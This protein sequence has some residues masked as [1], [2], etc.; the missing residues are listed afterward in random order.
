M[1]AMAFRVRPPWDGHW[2][3]SPPDGSAASAGAWVVVAVQSTLEQDSF[4]PAQPPGEGERRAS[5]RYPCT[6]RGPDHVVIRSGTQSCWARP[7]DV[8]V[9]GIGLLLA[10]PVTPG[11]ELTI[12]MRR[13]R[14]NLTALLGAAVVHARPQ[15]DGT[16]RAGCRF[17][18]A[19]S[20][21]E[22]EAF[23]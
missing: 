1:S 11:T 19:I 13:R 23:L 20:A 15:A 21:E 12:Q 3:A 4:C 22:V 8:S 2:P 10:Q 7:C 17:D 16:W 18:Q 9:G 5:V 14:E 6:G